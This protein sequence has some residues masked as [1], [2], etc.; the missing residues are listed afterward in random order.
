MNNKRPYI[1]GFNELDSQSIGKECSDDPA[2]FTDSSTDRNEYPNSSTSC[3]KAASMDHPVTL[4]DS[5]TSQSAYPRLSTSYIEAAAAAVAAESSEKKLKR[6]LK[7]TKAQDSLLDEVKQRNRLA[8][9][10]RSAA[11]SRERKRDLIENLQQT[12]AKLSKENLE[13]KKKCELLEQE[14]KRYQNLTFHQ[15]AESLA[16]LKNNGNNVTGGHLRFGS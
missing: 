11:L 9:N 16:A 13:L 5:S 1:P 12:V 15:M 3:I 2:K 10:R 8:A 14:L 6:A 7:E 4:D